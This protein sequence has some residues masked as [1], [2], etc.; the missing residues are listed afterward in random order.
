VSQLR[1]FRIARTLA[2]LGAAVVVLLAAASL[3]P[4]AAWTPDPIVGGPLFKPN[5]AL[6]FRW[7][8]ASTMP[9]SMK[10]AITNGA[11]DSTQSRQSKAPTY[12]YDPAGPNVV[13][14][15]G[16]VPCGTYGIACFVRNAP[17]G[18]T[19]WFREDGHRFDFGPL[20]W[21]EP[22]GFPNTC[23]EAETVMLDELGHVD[24]LDHHVNLPDGS[25]WTDAVMQAMTHGKPDLGWSVHAYERCDVSTLQALYDVLSAYTLYSTCSDI[26]SLLTV[27]ATKTSVT[28]GSMVAFTATLTSHG[29]GLLSNNAIAG[30][31]VV[32][33]ERSGTTWTD[34]ATM[35]AGSVGGTYITS[36]TMWSTGDYRALFR[37]P[38]NEGLRSTTSGVMTIT[39]TAT[40]TSNCPS[41][42]GRI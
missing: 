20:R 24:D 34:V 30:R 22:E 28:A 12:A 14:Y 40:C 2:A 9:S 21:C 16:S 1:S 18:F 35:G 17:T 4:A 37:K 13:Y 33:Q 7:G 29:A 3:A 10:V 41:L 26:P 38:S 6:N 31:T 39:V 23:P 32:I 42:G 5:Q 36:V 15:G 8:N 27:S 19:I 25:D 11:A